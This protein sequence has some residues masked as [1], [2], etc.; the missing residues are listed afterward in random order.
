MLAG[1]STDAVADE[2]R[3]DPKIVEDNPCITYHD[4]NK[5]DQSIVRIQDLEALVT[6]HIG[7]T[8]PVQGKRLF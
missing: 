8:D 3:Q 4:G 6:S 1:Q 5:C 7:E 2:L